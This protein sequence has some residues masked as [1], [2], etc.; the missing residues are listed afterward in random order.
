MQGNDIGTGYGKRIVIVL[1]P[2]LAEPPDPHLFG[3]VALTKA[4]RLKQ[5]EQRAE[6]WKLNDTMCS[7][8]RWFGYTHSIG[9]EVWSFLDQLTFDVLAERIAKICGDYVI[10]W[11][12]WDSLHDA[13]RR[14]QA[15]PDILTVYDAD[16][17]R[18]ERFWHFR[19]FRVPVGT[20]P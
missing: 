10:E 8:V 3:R 13:Y 19:G 14:L 18:I 7:W 11:E 2:T 9:T 17:D 12:R 6:R 5:A 1:E 15:T 16:I 20:A 4:G